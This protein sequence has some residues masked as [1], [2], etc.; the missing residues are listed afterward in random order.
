[1]HTRICVIASLVCCAT[2]FV[3]TARAADSAMTYSPTLNSTNQRFVAPE[4][5]AR[6]GESFFYK[7]AVAAS[8][9]QYGLAAHLYQVSASWAY[10]PAQYNLG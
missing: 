9:E 5:S 7:A 3:P 8:K 4:D 2:A 6:P 1:M 10:K